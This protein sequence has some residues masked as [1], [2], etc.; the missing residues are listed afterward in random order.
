MDDTKYW[1]WLALVFGNSNGRIWQIMCA[2][3]TAEEAYYELSSD[4]GM[5]ELKSK[6]KDN[7]KS[8][9]L[10]HAE[11]IIGEC[12]KKGIGI[13][14]Y[15]SEKYPARLRYIFNPPAILYYKGN[16]D[17]LCND[18]II[19]C[20]GTRNP[21]SYSVY[22]TRNICSEFA[23][24][25]VV[26]A[27]GFAVGIDIES[28]LSAVSRNMPTICV[29]GCGLDVN[30]PHDNFKYRDKII[31]SGGVFISEFNLAVQANGSNFPKRNRILS[32]LGRATV[33]FQASVKSGSLITANLAAEQGREVFCLPP[34]DIFSYEYSGNAELIRSGAIPLLS[35][36][37]VLA[38]LN[39]EISL[40]PDLCEN[41]LPEKPIKNTEKF[42]IAEDYII[43][44][45]DKD[46]DIDNKDADNSA[47]EE[48]TPEF[49]GI[50]NEIIKL[51][52]DG[53]VHVDVIAQ[54]LNINPTEL[55]TELTELEIIGAVKSLPGKMFEKKWKG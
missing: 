14:S 37:D 46:I 42:S 54:K 28:H 4:C 7:I 41:K 21:S 23:E 5:S 8:T 47:T 18:K 55:M 29:M 52:S 27:S 15:N 24:K 40:V 51:M 25:G 22:A 16:I 39:M 45:E 50:Q 12:G 3:E 36:D 33:V 44:A 43:D 26:I 34:H 11:A 32:A 31:D 13:I 20:V 1:L 49:E 6:E 10:Y 35:A 53:A 19:T 38:Y 48:E 2:F 17:Y 30:Y 9:Y